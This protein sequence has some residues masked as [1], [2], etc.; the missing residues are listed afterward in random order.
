MGK[1]NIAINH[2]LRNKRRF[3]DLYN[4]VHF[5]GKQRIKAEELT[6]ASEVYEEPEASNPETGERGER[7]ERIRDIKMALN[8]GK[9]LCILGVESQYTVNYSMPFRCMQ[10]D[11]MEYGK[12]LN[13]LRDKNAIENNYA[14]WA[15]KACGIKKN[16]RLI[17]ASTLCLYHGEYIW[18][19]PRTLKDMMQFDEDGSFLQS[20]FADYRFHLYCINEETDFSVF[21]TELRQVFELL[22]Y[23]QDKVKLWELIESRTEYQ[24]MDADSLEVLSVLLNAPKLWEDRIKYMKKTDEREE[25]NMCQALEELFADNWEAGMEA[26]IKEGIKEGIEEKTSQIVKNMIKRGMS[27]D[28]IKAIAECPQETID[29]LRR[30]L[31]LDKFL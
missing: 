8:K 14:D 20:L 2:Y 5:H 9:D 28:D 27:D 13:A 15:E 1:P 23:R 12:Q 22:Q 3:A 10:Y 21:H 11:T 31:P 25:Y 19:G 24:H 17:P 6:D 29:T 16:D 26:G 30:K 18:D 4:G 7:L